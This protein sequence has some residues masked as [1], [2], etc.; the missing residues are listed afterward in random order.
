V[1][2]YEVTFDDW[3]A[4]VAAAGCTRKPGDNGWDRG[5]RPVINVSWDNITNEYLPWLSRETGKT[6]R[7][8]TEAEW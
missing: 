1:G 7:L 3:D 6:Y 8:L 2:K 5:R 4:C